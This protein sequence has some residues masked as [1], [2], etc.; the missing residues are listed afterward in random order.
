MG[1]F[2]S[3]WGRETCPFAPLFKKMEST[4]LTT[5]VPPTALPDDLYC[6]FPATTITAT[7][8]ASQPIPPSIFKELPEPDVQIL[9]SSG[10]RI[11]AHS[12]I[13]V[14]NLLITSLI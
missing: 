14:I 4:P 9:T 5:S 10:L 13:L 7:D 12:G 6:N 1:E 3:V 8:T 11:P 2:V